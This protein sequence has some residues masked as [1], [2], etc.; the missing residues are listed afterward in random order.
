MEADPDKS[1]DQH[2][3]L[4]GSTIEKMNKSLNKLF[5]LSSFTVK[6]LP[7]LPRKRSQNRVMSSVQ[8]RSA[9]FSR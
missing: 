8:A 4:L 6:L 3:F 2:Y 1:S 7:A 5:R 9:A